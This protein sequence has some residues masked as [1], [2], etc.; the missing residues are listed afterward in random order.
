MKAWYRRKTLLIMEL[1]LMEEQT[2]RALYLRFV[3]IPTP[4]YILLKVIRMVNYPRAV[5]YRQVTETFMVLLQVGEHPMQEPFL[6]LLPAELLQYC[7]SWQ[8]T[9]MVA[10]HKV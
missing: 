2:T 7:A 5:L 10:C 9:R 6:R 8:V 3:V 4:S 1:H